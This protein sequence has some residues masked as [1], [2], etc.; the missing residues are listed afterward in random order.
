MSSMTPTV[1]TAALTS[2]G[3]SALVALAVEWAAKPRLEARKERILE[4]QRV[5]LRALTICR[6]IMFGLG[7]LS[8]RNPFLRDQ[9]RGLMIAETTRARNEL[10]ALADRLSTEMVNSAFMPSHDVLRLCGHTVGLLRGAAQSD[11]TNADV[12]EQ[13]MVPMRL[14]TVLLETSRSRWRKRIIARRG[15]RAYLALQDLLSDSNSTTEP[16]PTG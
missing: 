1:L 16:N 13:L 11:S 9:R 8:T 12:V 4:A 2:A 3:V 7:R 14:L 6:E 15:A 5:R 10:L